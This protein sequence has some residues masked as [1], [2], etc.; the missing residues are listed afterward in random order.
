MRRKEKTKSCVRRG[1]RESRDGRE[2][3][4]REEEKEGGAWFMIC[5]WANGLGNEE[6]L[7][8]CVGIGER[9]GSCRKGKLFL[10]Q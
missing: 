8:V 9:V 5:V 1:V 2:R 10:V 3:E 4:K 6:C 7:C